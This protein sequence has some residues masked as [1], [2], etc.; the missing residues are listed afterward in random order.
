MTDTANYY[1]TAFM[2]VAFAF[3]GSVVLL[4]GTVNA[5]LA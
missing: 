4:V 1:R 3:V 2:A 5:P